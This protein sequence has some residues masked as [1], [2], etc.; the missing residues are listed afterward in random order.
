VLRAADAE[1]EDLDPD[2]V[3]A[4]V[5]RYAQEA[6]KAH[7]HLPALIRRAVQKATSPND[8]PDWEDLRRAHD[9]PV[10]HEGIWEDL[11]EELL[12]RGWDQVERRQRARNPYDIG[13]ALAPR[14]PSLPVGALS[15]AQEYQEQGRRLRRRADD[16]HATLEASRAEEVLA[17]VG[18][19]QIGT[20]TGLRLGLAV[21]AL[22]AALQLV[23]PLL[24]LAPTPATLTRGESAGLVAA[25]VTG[26]V[27]LFGYLLHYAGRLTQASP[28][29][30]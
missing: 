5:N 22:L 7:S 29:R 13:Y 2:M 28:T 1:D 27:A 9:L 14:S 26:L 17:R 20:P 23:L 6:A 18:R 12:E 21:L 15:A 24:F 16:A 8:L 10:E 19:E 11:W 3:A 4:L 30:R 25:F